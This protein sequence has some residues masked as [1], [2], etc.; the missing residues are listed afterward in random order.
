MNA[1]TSI[2]VTGA[3]GFIGKAVCAELVRRGIP[4]LAVG[5]SPDPGIEEARYAQVT[6]YLQFDPPLQSRCIHLAGSRQIDEASAAHVEEE[7]R[8]A[9]RLVE[10]LLAKPFER[11]VVA[12]SASVYG[13]QI[14][15]PRREDER[16]TPASAYGSIKQLMG[17]LALLR[18]HTVARIANVYG[19]ELPTGSALSDILHQI[20]GEGA[21]AIRDA[22]PI[23]DYI[24]VHDVARGLVDLALSDVSGVFNLGTGVGRSIG[25]LASTCIAHSNQPRRS[26]ISQAGEQRPSVVILDPGKMRATLGWQPAKRIEDGLKELVAWWLETTAQAVR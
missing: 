20:P 2:V 10:G 22:A 12:S 8:S 24:H 5:R 9:V 1:H 25:W 21:L 11:M 23:R 17:K 6:D 7:H 15:T 14:A 13:D 3:S 19:P 18:G 26:M 16:V 4:V